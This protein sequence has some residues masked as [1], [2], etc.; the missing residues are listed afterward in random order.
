MHFPLITFKLTNSLKN[1]LESWR[2]RTSI[3]FSL[4][5]V[6]VLWQQFKLLAL[7]FL[8]ICPY[9][10]VDIQVS[11]YNKTTTLWHLQICLGV[12]KEEKTLLKHN[13]CTFTNFVPRPTEGEN[14]SHKN[15]SDPWMGNRA[16]PS[17]LNQPSELH[18]YTDL[19]MKS[20]HINCCFL[21]GLHVSHAISSPFK[22]LKPFSINWIL[23]TGLSLRGR[24]QGFPQ[25]TE[26]VTPAYFHEKIEEK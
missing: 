22:N 24:G 3:L 5:G 6:Y 2:V 25:A 18:S 26:N 4:K 11:D 20:W 9:L 21:K 10:Y 8:T 23:N 7:V 12:L 1:H 13:D 16:V 17:H 19:L 14:T 15:T